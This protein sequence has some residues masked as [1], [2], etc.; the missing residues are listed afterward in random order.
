MTQILWFHLQIGKLRHRVKWLAQGQWLIVADLVS[1]RKHPCQ[2]LL[3]TMAWCCFSWGQKLCTKRVWVKYRRLLFKIHEAI[4]ALEVEGRIY[5]RWVT[6]FRGKPAGGLW[7]SGDSESAWLRMYW[8]ANWFGFCCPEQGEWYW[9]G[10]ST[11]PLGGVWLSWGWRSGAELPLN[12]VL[13]GD[14]GS[15]RSWGQLRFYFLLTL[16]W[17]NYTFAGS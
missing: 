12:W 4:L 6:G 9:P 7:G 10:A 8:E 16:F 17:N 13:K 11:H 3:S 14:P 15:L 5:W 1:K 2:T